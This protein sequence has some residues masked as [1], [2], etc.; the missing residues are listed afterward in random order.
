MVADTKKVRAVPCVPLSV[1]VL[2]AHSDRAEFP[3]FPPFRGKSERKDGPRDSV[4]G[5]VGNAND[6][7][8]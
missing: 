2:A 5:W 3:G 4:V 8:E 7:A 1:K 6:K